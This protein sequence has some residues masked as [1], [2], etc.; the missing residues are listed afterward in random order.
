[1]RF[2]GIDVGSEQHAVAIVN[3]SG[4]PLQRSTSITEDAAGYR[5]L[6]DQLGDTTDCLIAMEATGH[7]WKNMFAYLTA[8]G[9]DVAILNPIRTR[10]FAEEE[11]QRTKTDHV[12]ALGIAR[13]A[14]QKRPKAIQLPEPASQEL[15][16]LVHLRHQAVQHLGDRV[17]NLHRAIDLTFPEFTVHGLDTELA[18]AILSRYPSARAISAVTIRK[19]ATLCFDGRRRDSPLV[20]NEMLSA[21]PK[22]TRRL[23]RPPTP[24][25]S[26]RVLRGA[27]KNARHWRRRRSC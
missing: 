6:R 24:Q 14:A 4:E 8:E 9:F 22:C 21:M 2:V 16:Q 5:R 15:R 11:L 7:Y 17:R 12:D 26:T 3:E 18:T 27:Q 25:L 20:Q 19:L 1:M 13:F 23:T 10:R